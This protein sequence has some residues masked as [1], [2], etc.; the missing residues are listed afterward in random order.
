MRR[1]T[2]LVQDLTTLTLQLVEADGTLLCSISFSWADA[3]VVVVLPPGSLRHM[4][5][6]QDVFNLLIR[7][8]ESTRDQVV[9]SLPRYGYTSAQ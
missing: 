6:F 4:G 9:A 3:G 8:P 7:Y 1:R 5:S 2:F